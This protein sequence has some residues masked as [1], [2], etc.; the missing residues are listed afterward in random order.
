[1]R[2][3][4]HLQ[5]SLA[6]LLGKHGAALLQ[7]PGAL[8]GPR[9][10]RR[11]LSPE[12]AQL[13]LQGGCVAAG[14]VRGLPRFCAPLSGSL[15]SCESKGVSLSITQNRTRECNR[16]FRLKT[17]TCNAHSNCPVLQ[18]MHQISAMLIAKCG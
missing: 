17:S 1:M 7:L 2:C 14:G 13:A 8:G 5:L 15:W 11:H 10:R 12:V 4:T 16:M 9:L 6:V 18:I 3:P